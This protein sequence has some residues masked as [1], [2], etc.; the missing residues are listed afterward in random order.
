MS[1]ERKRLGKKV[2]EEKLYTLREGRE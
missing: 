2:R 1:K